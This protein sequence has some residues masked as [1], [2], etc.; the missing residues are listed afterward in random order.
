MVG[1]SS[2]A[3][4]DLNRVWNWLVCCNHHQWSSF[5]IHSLLE[6]TFS[7]NSGQKMLPMNKLC[8]LCIVT[9][10]HLFRLLLIL[11]LEMVETMIIEIS[12]NKVVF[13]FFFKYKP[14]LNVGKSENYMLSKCKEAKQKQ[15][16]M[17]CRGTHLYRL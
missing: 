9:V 10:C 6:R 1:I 16:P 8:K 15:N 7:G 2:L 14:A 12:R 4:F 5:F 17:V 3:C 13:F 11:S